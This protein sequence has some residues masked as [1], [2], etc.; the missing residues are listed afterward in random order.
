MPKISKRERKESTFNKTVELFAKYDGF[1]LVSMSDVKSKQLQDMR[2][3]WGANTHLLMGKN[4]VIKKALALNAEKYPHFEKIAKLVE[5]NVAFV[6]TNGGYEDVKK[7]I[8]DNSRDTYASEGQVAQKD[9][10]VEKCITGM[11]PDKTNFFQALGISTRITKGKVE[12]TGRCKALTEGERVGPSQASLL[13]L[14]DIKPFTYFMGINALYEDG[15]IYEP[16]VIDIT[17][18]DVDVSLRKCIS[19]LSSIS[20]GAR[21]STKASIPYE[22]INCFKSI[23]GVSLASGYEIRE[24]MAFKA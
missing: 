15:V 8:M 6:F 19:L 18:E 24:A 17:D 22:I 23:V 2:I 5:G 12:I 20:L 16:S 3:S 9:V 7:V 14:L 1:L 11:G 4:T 13:T 21:Y 10:W